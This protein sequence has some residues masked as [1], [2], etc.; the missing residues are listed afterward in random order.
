MTPYF[1]DFF[2]WAA[3]PA[4]LYLQWLRELQDQYNKKVISF[5]AGG[6][7]NRPQG[8]HGFSGGAAVQL[9]S[10]ALSET[11]PASILTPAET[12]RYIAESAPTSSYVAEL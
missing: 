1:R 4:G 7:R 3:L 11:P 10:P 9:G 8:A 2:F 12:Y 5:D 6:R